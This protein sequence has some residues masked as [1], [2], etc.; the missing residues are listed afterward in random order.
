MGSPFKNNNMTNETK[1]IKALKEQLPNDRAAAQL[2]QLAEHDNAK[3]AELARESLNETGQL[4]ATLAALSAATTEKAGILL[5][6]VA[7]F[8]HHQLPQQ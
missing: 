6:I 2:L 5:Q 8:H 7:K 4:A 1:R 3:A